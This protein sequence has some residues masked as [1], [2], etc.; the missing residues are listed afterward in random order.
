MVVKAVC[1]IED[2]SSRK[3]LSYG[4]FDAQNTPNSKKVFQRVVDEF[5]KIHPLDEL[6]MDHGSACGAHRTDELGDWDGEFK[7]F[8]EGYGI[9]PIRIRVNHP[10]SNGKI[11]KWFDVYEKYRWEFSTFDEFVHWYNCIRPHESL[12]PNGLKTPE[13]AFWER[14]PEEAGR[15]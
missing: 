11:E 1:V 10:Q 12:D 4:E 2:D 14:L 3:I 7:R 13:E 9:K 15:V 6:I 8:I 5:W